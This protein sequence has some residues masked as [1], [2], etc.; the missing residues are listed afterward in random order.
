M[1]EAVAETVSSGVHWQHTN[2]SGDKNVYFWDGTEN[3]APYADYGTVE[4]DHPNDCGF[5]EIAK[6]LSIILENIHSC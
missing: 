2:T 1:P 5:W 4:G 6:S 3:F